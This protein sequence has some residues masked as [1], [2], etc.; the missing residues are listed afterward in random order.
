MSMLEDFEQ[1]IYISKRVTNVL[2]TFQADV[3]KIAILRAKVSGKRRATRSDR[4]DARLRR[5]VSERAT[6]RGYPDP[7]SIDRGSRTETKNDLPLHEKSP[8]RNLHRD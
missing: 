1:C 7:R 8:S 3:M 4:V 2:R 5:Y 6:T